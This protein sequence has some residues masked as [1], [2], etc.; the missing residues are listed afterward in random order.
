MP[1]SCCAT[2][3]SSSS[4]GGRRSRS[5]ASGWRRRPGCWPACPTSSSSRLCAGPTCSAP[6]TWAWRLACC[7]AGSRSTPAASGSP[8]RGARCRRSVASTLAAS[9]PPRP[10]ARSRPWCCSAPTRWPT[11][12][13][14]PWPAARWVVPASSSPSTSSSP[15]PPA[16][17]TWC[18]P[19]PGRGRRPAP[20]PTSK[21]ESAF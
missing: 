7:P 6:S 3:T 2:A 17:P 16:M 20:R 11:S 13:I 10:R 14:G 19:R 21:V 8:T 18:W 1:V 15:S 9:C 4:W 12:P 5:P